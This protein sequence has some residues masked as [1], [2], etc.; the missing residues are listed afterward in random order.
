MDLSTSLVF[1]FKYMIPLYNKFEEILKVLVLPLPLIQD[2][3]LM[4]F[5][6]QK[7]LQL[8]PPLKQ[9]AGMLRP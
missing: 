4:M 8:A 1:I 2:I 7:K 9:T 6:E 5:L 3:C